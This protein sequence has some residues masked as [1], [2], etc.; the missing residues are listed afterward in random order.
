VSNWIVVAAL[1]AVLYFASTR[2]AAAAGSGGG[3]LAP[4]WQPGDPEYGVL[5]YGGGDGTG[6]GGGRVYDAGNPGP[7]RDN[8]PPPPAPV[9]PGPKIITAAPSAQPLTSAGGMRAFINAP[10]P[11]TIGPETRDLVVLPSSRTSAG[12]VTIINPRSPLGFYR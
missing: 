9:T 10:R 11:T 6:G 3:G 1:I 12:P 4:S 5:G 2:S 7:L 8:A